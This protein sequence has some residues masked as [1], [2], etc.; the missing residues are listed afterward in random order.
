MNN[1]E[2]IIQAACFKWFWNSFPQYRYLLFAVPNGGLRSK[3]TA[4]VMASTG[5]V[6]GIPDLI[7]VW[8]GKCFGLECK[9]PG[10][11]LTGQQPKVHSVWADKGHPIT[12]FYSLEE[13]QNILIN[14]IAN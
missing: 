3:Q 12:I 9:R 4:S 8:Q 2:D 5:T 1:T 13:F 11:G 7:F 14:I 6:A 10:A